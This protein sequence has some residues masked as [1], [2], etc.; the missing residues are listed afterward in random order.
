MSASGYELKCHLKFPIFMLYPMEGRD[1]L[2][3]TSHMTM[4]TFCLLL[5]FILQFR[6]SGKNPFKIPSLNLTR[7]NMITCTVFLSILNG[8]KASFTKMQQ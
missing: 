1:V 3:T 6:A 8:D 5:P 7:K 4:K 2:L